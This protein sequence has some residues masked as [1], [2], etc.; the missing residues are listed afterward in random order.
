MCLESRSACNI[1]E[2]NSCTVW[3]SWVLPVGQ[4]MFNFT[5]H[6]NYVN[7]GSNGSGSFSESKL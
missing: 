7:D 4:L 3:F 1:N 2:R 6:L 5:Y